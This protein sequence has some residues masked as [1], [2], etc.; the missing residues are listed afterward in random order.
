MAK[1]FEDLVKLDDRFEIMAERHL[2]LV[3]FRLK[4]E[5]EITEKLLKQL[6]KDGRLHVVPARV[7]NNY[8]IRFTVTSYYTT[9]ED[10]KR[11]WQIIQ[12]TADEILLNVHQEIMIREEKRKFQSSLLLSNVPQTPKL[13]NASFLAFFLDPDI[14]YDIVRELTNRDYSRSHLPLTP[15]RKPKLNA[16]EYQKGLSLD[17]LTPFSSQILAALENFNNKDE[18]TNLEQQKIDKKSIISVNGNSNNKNVN[19]SKQ[20][21]EENDLVVIKKSSKFT[22]KQASLDSKIEHIF[23]EVEEADSQSSA[24]GETE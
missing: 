20:N 1:L 11:D 12:S 10:I 24:N 5:N 6:N 13:V 17:Q 21:S 14:T 23:E 2:G 8:I 15:R 7:K 3:V 16:N 4:G 18:Q 9:E 22:V 19:R